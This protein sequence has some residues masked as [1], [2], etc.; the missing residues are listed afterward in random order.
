MSTPYNADLYFL[1]TARTDLRI[2][3]TQR[4][5]AHMAEL[6]IQALDG[7]HNAWHPNLDAPGCWTCFDLSGTDEHDS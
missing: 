6:R 3:L 2:S 7:I 5:L 1:S 4:Q